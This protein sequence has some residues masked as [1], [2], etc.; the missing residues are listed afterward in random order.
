MHMLVL[1][2]HGA[3]QLVGDTVCQIRPH[4]ALG[5]HPP[6]LEARDLREL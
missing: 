6:A 4:S 3:D 5:H 2:C 1:E